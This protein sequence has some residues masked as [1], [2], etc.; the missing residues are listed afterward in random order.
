MGTRDSPVDA[1]EG[2]LGFSLRDKMRH[3]LVPNSTNHPSAESQIT[4]MPVAE[5]GRDRTSFGSVVEPP[6]G[7]FDHAPIV[8]PRS[9]AP[10]VCGRDRRLDFCQLRVCQALRHLHRR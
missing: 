8:P 2:Q 6:D 3:D 1:G 4:M 9:R 10:N 5:L 7:Y